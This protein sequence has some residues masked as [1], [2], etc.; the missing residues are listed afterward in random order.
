[1]FKVFAIIACTVSFLTPNVYAGFDEDIAAINKGM[2]KSVKLFN[3]R[4]IEC[5][6]WAGE[7]PTDK[8]RSKE[9]NSAITK[10]RCKDLE[11]D[12]VKLHQKFKSRSDIVKSIKLAKEFI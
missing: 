11:K 4:Q 12:E 3:M 6:H 1:M 2:P 8:Q 9:I 7:E 10:L 5:N